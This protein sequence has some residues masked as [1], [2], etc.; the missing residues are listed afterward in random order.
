MPQAVTRTVQRLRAA[1]AGFTPAT[2]AAAE[3]LPSFWSRTS[4]NF[5]F[6]SAETTIPATP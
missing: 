1:V 3:I 4:K 5:A 2:R 6:N